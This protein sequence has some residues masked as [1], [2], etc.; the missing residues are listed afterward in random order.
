M[1]GFGEIYKVTWFGNVNESNG[2]GIIYPIIAKGSRLLASI[3]EFF[4][5]SINVSSDQTII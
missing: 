1:V 4:S 3:V 2:W 5:D